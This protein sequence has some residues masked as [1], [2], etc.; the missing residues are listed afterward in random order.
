VGDPAGVRVRPVSPPAPEIA[1]LRAGQPITR[2]EAPAALLAALR[3]RL[4]PAPVGSNRARLAKAPVAKLPKGAAKAAARPT[5]VAAAVP[6]P[7]AKPAAAEPTAAAVTLTPGFYVQYAALSALDR[8]TALAKKVD[9]VV[10]QTDAVFRV[11]RGPFA[12]DADAKRERARA[13]GLGY[14]D[15]QI[16]RIIP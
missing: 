15:A 12:N 11:H 13:V 16:V 4:G 2:A 3:K 5:S 6:P 7:P 9:G 1:A 10:E 14:R 8:A